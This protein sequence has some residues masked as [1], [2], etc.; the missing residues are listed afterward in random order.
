MNI[1]ELATGH[2]VRAHFLINLIYR[3]QKKKINKSNITM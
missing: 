1:Q 3:M 2:K